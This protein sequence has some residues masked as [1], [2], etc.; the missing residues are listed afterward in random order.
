VFLR[1]R[2]ATEIVMTA[3]EQLHEEGR[4]EGHKEGREQTQRENLLVLLNR[5]FGP[6]PEQALA[7][8][9]HASLAQLQDWFDRGIT[10]QS[11]DA[12]FADKP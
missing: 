5:R 9:R 2:R 11:L 12:V 3:A 7:R 6:L 4:K 10:A 8:I 1:R